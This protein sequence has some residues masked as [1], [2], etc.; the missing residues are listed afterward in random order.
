MPRPKKEYTPITIKLEKDLFN[1]L[2]EYCEIAG[3]SKTKATE[4]ALKMY[5]DA[6]E[7]K[8]G[9][10]ITGKEKDK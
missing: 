6:Y 10:A 9:V 3:Q 1:R 8:E 2:S 4:R 7:Q 5:I